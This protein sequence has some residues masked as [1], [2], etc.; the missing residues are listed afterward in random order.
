[1]R[2]FLMALNTSAG[3]VNSTILALATRTRWRLWVWCWARMLPTRQTRRVG[4]VHRI[5]SHIPVK[6][7]IA[8]IKANRIFVHETTDLGIVVSGAVVIQVALRVEFPGVAIGSRV[9]VSLLTK[10][11][12]PDVR[13]NLLS[14]LTTL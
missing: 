3:N 9:G 4:I 14:V 12:L 7:L 6:V 13:K 5:V 10:T 1:M 8:S 2:E 11:P